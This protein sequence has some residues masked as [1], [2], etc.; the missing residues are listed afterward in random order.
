MAST[1]VSGN[2]MDASAVWIP[3]Q[4]HADLIQ[5]EIAGISDGPINGIR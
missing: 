4:V 5:E 1:H 2:G 3:E